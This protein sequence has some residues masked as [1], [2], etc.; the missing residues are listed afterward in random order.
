MLPELIVAAK[1]AKTAFDITK[2]FVS[3]DKDS[4]VNDKAIELQ[5]IIMSLQQNLFD[6][7]SN[8]QSL[9]DNKE[10]IH[11]ELLNIQNW[12]EK[13]IKYS[14]SELATDVFVYTKKEPQNEIEKSIKYCSKCFQEQKAS[15]IQLDSDNLLEKIYVCHT[16]GSEYK[17]KSNGGGSTGF[18]RI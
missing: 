3:L 5:Q 14:L 11:K 7:Q 17:V 2:Y 9:L 8:Y 16:C 4:A 6:A 10:R 18:S 1:S 15:I 12:N 13:K